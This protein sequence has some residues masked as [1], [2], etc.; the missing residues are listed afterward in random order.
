MEQEKNI[1]VIGGG[2][3]ATALIKILSNNV[4]K[5]NWYMRNE[6]AVEHILKFKHN[7]NYV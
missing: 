3:W 6:G 2:S 7:P 1:A 4:S 5:I